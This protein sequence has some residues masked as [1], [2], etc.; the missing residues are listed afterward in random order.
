MG[1]YTG[2]CVDIY[3][4]VCIDNYISNYRAIIEVS[5][6]TFIETII[7]LPSILV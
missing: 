2:D 1:V 5:V 6:E 4:A 7:R 3:R